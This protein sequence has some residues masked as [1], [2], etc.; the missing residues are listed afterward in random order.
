MVNASPLL[1]DGSPCILPEGS[2]K[3]T[4][5]SKKA[6]LSYDPKKSICTLTASCKDEHENFQETS[7]SWKVHT[8]HLK[9][10][11]GVLESKKH[12]HKPK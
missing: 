3:D 4:C 6:S 9:N 5:D 12:K 2:W 1:A 7:Y 8:P 10:T 11:N